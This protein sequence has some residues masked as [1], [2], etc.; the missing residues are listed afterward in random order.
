MILNYNVRIKD[1]EKLKE[2]TCVGVLI[3]SHKI[4]LKSTSMGLQQGM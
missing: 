2:G 3:C 4:A 1:V